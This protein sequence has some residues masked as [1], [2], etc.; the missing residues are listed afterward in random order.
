MSDYKN[1]LLKASF[2]LYEKGIPRKK[3][4]T[5]VFKFLRLCGFEVRLP[6]YSEPRKVFIYCTLYFMVLIAVL[7]GYVQWKSG[8]LNPLSLIS[9]TVIFGVLAGAFMM[10]L[11]ARNQKKFELTPWDEL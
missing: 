1:K 11:T 6:P 3:S 2:E 10:W 7:Y 9:A 4:H 5:L 8:A